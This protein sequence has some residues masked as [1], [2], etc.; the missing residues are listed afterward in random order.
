MLITPTTTKWCCWQQQ[1]HSTH[2]QQ[3]TMKLTAQEC[4]SLPMNANN[5]PHMKMTTLQIKMTAYDCKWPPT[6]GN[7]SPQMKAHAHEWKQSPTLWNP[8]AMSLTVMQQPNDK[9]WM[10]FIVDFTTQGKYSPVPCSSQPIWLRCRTT[11]MQGRGQVTTI[12]GHATTTTYN[13]LIH[14]TPLPTSSLVLES[15]VQS[16][17]LAQNNKSE[18]ETGPDIS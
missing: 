13:P 11:I 18:T 7:N 3:T 5:C 4:K 10:S 1:P 15:P 14:F 9:W 2:C 17:F 8:D 6:K 16:G 12:T